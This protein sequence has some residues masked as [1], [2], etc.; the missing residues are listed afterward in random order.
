MNE[1]PAQ[2]PTT[3]EVEKQLDRL[4]SSTYFA[5]SPKQA[6]LLRYIVEFSLQHKEKDGKEIAADVFPASDPSSTNVKAN[7]SF[8]R[9]K[10]DDYY[11]RE[12]AND[13]VGIELPIGRTYK[14]T[15]SYRHNSFAFRQY[16]KARRGIGHDGRR[17]ARY[18][19][20]LLN[21][22]VGHDK[23]LT[24]AHVA[25]LQALICD[26]LL[27]NALAIGSYEARCYFQIPLPLE[28]QTVDLHGHSW[29]AWALHGTAR[30]LGHDKESA[31]RAFKRAI[32][33]DAASTETNIMYAFYL[34]LTGERAA[35][36]KVAEASHREDD[37]DWMALILGLFFYL[38][39][40]MERAG[41]FI[42]KLWVCADDLLILRDLLH[43]L[44]C[45][46]CGQNETALNALEVASRISD[47]EW[48][49]PVPGYHEGPK[50]ERFAGLNI[51]ALVRCGEGE[52]ANRMFTALRARRNAKPFQLAV[53]CVALGRK[54]KA[55]AYLRDAILAGDIFASALNLW[56][57][58]D[59]L[60][61]CKSFRSLQDEIGHKTVPFVPD[62][63]GDW[64]PAVY[65]P[66]REGLEY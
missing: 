42:S 28:Q 16:E 24:V 57:F 13:L 31:G 66:S 63:G 15:F 53:A 20:H 11:A 45:L 6:E 60:K 43:G 48:N 44:I 41:D 58:F 62:P 47:D 23:S 38:A 18:I 25:I 50:A 7:V 54:R 19:L 40:D 5:A 14:A 30:L 33:T 65:I 55:V 52:K 56:P 17:S 26:G 29:L 36:I 1:K 2:L 49:S 10:I 51:V 12:G 4:T 39:R 22:A 8:V 46:E 9:G 61:N 27:E 35:A 37:G 59:D 34:L 3:L 21:L 64:G 32:D